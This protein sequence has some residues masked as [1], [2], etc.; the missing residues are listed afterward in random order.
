MLREKKNLIGQ[1]TKFFSVKTGFG[2]L[3]KVNKISF[4]KN[5][6]KSRNFGGLD[7]TNELKI[8]IFIATHFPY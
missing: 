6:R 8:I 7:A 3:K 1:S 2:K 5:I 4:E